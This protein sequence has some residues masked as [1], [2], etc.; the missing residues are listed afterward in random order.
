MKNFKN[1]L[2][3]AL[4][5]AKIQGNATASVKDAVGT[6]IV[7]TPEGW[8]V[9][10]HATMVAWFPNLGHPK[11]NSGGFYTGTT[12]RRMNQALTLAGENMK[13]RRSKGTFILTICGE[14]RIWFSHNCTISD[15]AVS[16]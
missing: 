8:G 6:T 13:V 12:V 1:A 2:G 3:F 10:Y 7:V 14:N 16:I 15:E 5:K 4:S 9:K 11:L